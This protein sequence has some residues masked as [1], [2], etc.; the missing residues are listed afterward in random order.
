MPKK[1]EKKESMEEWSRR[2]FGYTKYGWLYVDN[3]RVSYVGPDEDDDDFIDEDGGIGWLN[4]L[5]Q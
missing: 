5:V 2:V 3:K 1:K 4:H